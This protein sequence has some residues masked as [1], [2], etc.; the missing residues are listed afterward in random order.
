M[1]KGQIEE[2]GKDLNEIITKKL[3]KTVNIECKNEIINQ[4]CGDVVDKVCHEIRTILEP[5]HNT[6]VN[7]MNV[8]DSDYINCN[9]ADILCYDLTIFSLSHE[10]SESC[11]ILNDKVVLGIDYIP[12]GTI[13]QILIY[14]PEGV[15]YKD[16]L[17]YHLN[18]IIPHYVQYDLYNMA[19]NYIVSHNIIQE[20]KLKNASCYI[21]EDYGTKMFSLFKYPLYYR[22]RNYMT[23]VYEKNEHEFKRYINETIEKMMS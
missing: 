1:W 5:T 18:T 19:K 9:R 3:T 13:L 7:M 16:T 23:K 15:N 11:K 4:I 21:N 20:I 14:G 17:M 12:T 2:M 6:K 10:I 8:F 22:L